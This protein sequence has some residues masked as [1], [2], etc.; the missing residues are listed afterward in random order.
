[1]NSL[2]LPIFLTSITT[3]A[4]FLM[5]LFS[6][7]VSLTGYGITIAF[8][9]M[10][11][12]LLSNTMLPALIMLLSWD[13]NSKAISKPSFVEKTMKVFGTLVTKSPKKV[14][15]SGILITLFAIGGIFLIKVEVQYNKMFREGNI[16]RD[17]FR[18]IL[19]AEESFA[20]SGGTYTMPQELIDEYKNIHKPG[21]PKGTKVLLD[22]GDMLV[23]SGCELEHWREPFEGQICGQVFL[24]YNHRNGPFAEQN[25]FDRRPMLG[26]PSITKK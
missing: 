25:K 4:A 15:F 24:H 17:S 23:Y 13:P 12:W 18:G 20:L 5:L 26:L 9:I 1:M 7:I 8:G 16:I 14:L 2:F 19:P 6:P 21:A 11:A 10:W 3:S 22:I